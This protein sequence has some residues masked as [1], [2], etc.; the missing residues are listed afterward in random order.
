M[1]CAYHGDI[2]AI[3]FCIHC[4]R[5][6]C[7]P[8]IH[9]VR[10]NAFCESCL[11]DALGGRTVKPPSM[12]AGGSS[13]EAAFILGLIPGVG[14]IYNAEYF[15]AAMHLLIFGSLMTILDE[16]RIA[17]GL[18]ALLSF[19]FYVYMPFEAY[20]TAKKRKFARDGIAL[21]TPFDQLN[22]RLDNIQHKDL[23]GG[24][25]LVA[26]GTVFLGVNFGVVSV[27]RIV[28]FWPVVLIGTG[29]FMLKRFQEKTSR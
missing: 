12:P 17:G 8:C 2:E 19:V 22:E 24:V 20:Y 14:A 15:K 27:D 13:P 7:P 5:A 25:I 4:G 21:Q 11:A 29:I 10:G 1:N 26:V 23:W 16:T 9:Q 18:F 3:A 28:R 6:L